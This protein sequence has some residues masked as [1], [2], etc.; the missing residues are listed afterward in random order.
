MEK[1]VKNTRRWLTDRQGRVRI[2]I[3]RIATTNTV[4]LKD[5]LT[6]S[7]RIAWTS[8]LEEEDS[9]LPLGFGLDPNL[10]Y[11]SYPINGRSVVGT[12]N[13]P[14]QNYVPALVAEKTNIDVSGPLIYSNKTGDVTSVCTGGGC[15][16]TTPPIILD[17]ELNALTAGL[18]KAL[19]E[20]I[21]FIY[22]FSSD[23]RKYILFSSSPSE[24]G[25]VYFGNRGC[26]ITHT[27]F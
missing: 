5:M 21:N 14:S 23:E 19:P 1:S 8:D 10:L 15:N 16:G 17:E 24:P 12:I 22:S 18:N 20:S 4:W 13:L 11:V 9:M 3:S 7:W 26:R 6:G 25:V 2:R 27:N